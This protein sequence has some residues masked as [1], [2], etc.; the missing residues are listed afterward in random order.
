MYT[1][2]DHHSIWGW[3][4]GVSIESAEVVFVWNDFSLKSNIVK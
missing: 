1:V 2:V 3:E 4:K